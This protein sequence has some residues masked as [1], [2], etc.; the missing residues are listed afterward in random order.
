MRT[1]ASRHPP[2]V[3]ILLWGVMIAAELGALRG[4]AP[5]AW[6]VVFRLV[7]GSFA[8]CGLVAWRRRPGNRSGRLMVATGLSFL[9]GPLFESFDAPVLQTLGLLLGDVWIV[10]LVVLLLS[11][12]S[13]R[14]LRTATDRAL[15]GSLA[16]AYVV[17]GVV[18]L[19]FLDDPGNLL[20]AFPDADAADAIDTVQRSLGLGASVATFAVLARR[21][22]LAT[23]PLRRALVPS[24]AGGVSLLLL[25]AL[26]ASDIVTGDPTHALPALTW[27]CVIGLL[28]T[29]AA[30]LAGL[31]RTRLARG[32][33]A[34][35]VVELRG[36]RGGALEAALSRTLRDP[37]L[38]LAGWLPE[39]GAYVDADGQV[40]L[41]PAPGSDRRSTAIERDDRPIALLVHD[42]S[43][44]DEPEA[45]EAVCAAAALALEN[46]ALQT[47]SRARL[48]ELQASRA[49]IVEAGDTERR[50][51]ERNLHDGAQQ[52]L[53]AVALQLRL[54]RARAG[55]PAA[56]EELATKGGED[57]AA[58]LDEL[59]EL[60]RGIHPAVL[61]HGLGAAL[62]SLAARSPLLTTLSLDTDQPLPQPIELAVYFVASEA[63]AN[64]AKYAHATAVTLRVARNG[65]SVSVE[66]ADNGVGG[67]DAAHGSGLRG[68][69]DRVEA[70]G[71]ALRVSSP[72]GGGTTV[73]A[74][75]PCAS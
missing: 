16:F 14:R 69:E 28:L 43:L 15:V 61:D 50:R 19:L 41:P 38:V 23:P 68:L 56:V 53:V 67:A 24:L 71:G 42:R 32:G 18:W 21:W 65:A 57:V 7:G 2:G 34:E 37:T 11:F 6:D 46:E 47:E 52:R 44:D 45:L 13:G 63:L 39:Y 3:W 4:P 54:I 22:W 5:P 64:V 26:L 48:S 70:L 9:A 8:A 35:L 29:P 66:I 25:A 49:R 40:V 10:L 20:A 36:L 1:P 62:E 72:P 74:E 59:R 75:L 33:F 27:A 55:D 51:L 17:L 12:P 58:A 31:L 60:A 73:S 30:F